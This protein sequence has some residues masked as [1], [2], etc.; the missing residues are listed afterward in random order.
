LAVKNDVLVIKNHENIELIVVPSSMRGKVCR[1]YHDS[2]TGGHMRF[3]KTY[4]TI[5]CRFYWPK[6]KSDIFE[7]CS[8]CDICQK[9]KAKNSSNCAPMISIR[10][11]KPW[12]LFAIDA[13]GPLK[14]TPRGNRNFLLGVDINSKFVITRATPDITG[15]TTIQYAREDVINKF[16]RPLAILSDQGRNFESKAFDAFCVEYGIKKIRTT[17]YHPQCNGL[18]E[19]S[20]RTIKRLVEERIKRAQEHQKRQYDKNVHDKVTYGTGDLVVLANNKQTVGQVRSFEPKYVGPYRVIRKVGDVDYEIEIVENG[21]TLVVH[22]NRMFEYT[23][24]NELVRS[25]PAVLAA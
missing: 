4:K 21:K 2:I 17:S 24:R 13:A 5:S 7:F 11:G 6:M 16:G 15:E 14:L 12:D 9:F 1:L 10:V 25:G 18:A 22:Y 20:I 8:S 23:A 3:E 19:R